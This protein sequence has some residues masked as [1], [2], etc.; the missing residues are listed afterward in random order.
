MEIKEKYSIRRA[1]RL[2]GGWD[3]GP[4]E[5]TSLG[6][7]I[8]LPP[9]LEIPPSPDAIAFSAQ[10]RDYLEDALTGG[11]TE[12]T[13]VL[14]QGTKS[15]V[16][17]R[18]LDPQFTDSEDVRQ[19]LDAVLAN[20]IP[21]YE[22]G[23]L[24]RVDF[25]VIPGRP[26]AAVATFSD[27][28][29]SQLVL[30]QRERY[31]IGDR[32]LFITPYFSLLDPLP[33]YGTRIRAS[34]RNFVVAVGTDE[35]MVEVC[36]EFPEIQEHRVVGD[37]RV[38]CRTETPIQAENVVAR[39]RGRFP[40][41]ILA[42]P[43]PDK[44]VEYV[45]LPRQTV[46]VLRNPRLTFAEVLADRDLT[47]PRE[48]DRVDNPGEF[49][50]LRIFNVFSLP[51]VKNEVMWVVLKDELKKRA[52]KYGYV[53]AITFPDPPVCYG[54]HTYATIK[55]STRNA[56]SVAQANLAGQYFLGRPVIT[57]LCNT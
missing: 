46:M 53:E 12:M 35:E 57:Q 32:A 2:L 16:Y 37:G 19:A 27:P 22:S 55:F 33:L 36:R 28:L 14:Y 10:L 48:L 20:G 4:E 56:A 25:E 3:V 41:A 15:Q 29:T 17:L 13:D 30:R 26:P 40:A 24:V 31:R 34:R 6:F 52:V 50:S 51:M 11:F 49:N 18:D 43:A 21:S 8:G 54:L 1:P 47:E 23:S 39:M 45:T 9:L 38:V 7:T 44:D 5:F 42:F